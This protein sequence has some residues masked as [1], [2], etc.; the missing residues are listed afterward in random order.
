MQN[1]KTKNVSSLYE[2]GNCI[3]KY[4]FFCISYTG[5]QTS[6]EQLRKR[7]QLKETAIIGY[8]HFMYIPPKQE[9]LN[10]LET[11]KVNAIKPPDKLF[12]LF[13]H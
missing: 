9:H 10:A 1:A 3:C 7:F 2:E 4:Y 6:E 11:I 13:E 12:S 8:N 5:Y